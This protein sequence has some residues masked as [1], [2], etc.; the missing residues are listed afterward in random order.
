MFWIN[1]FGVIKARFGLRKGQICGLQGQVWGYQGQA[2]KTRFGLAGPGLGLSEPGLGF[3][4]KPKISYAT[5]KRTDQ[6]RPESYHYISN[7]TIL[8]TI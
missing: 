6:S 2:S 4:M 8:F 7:D 1:R 3:V 5:G